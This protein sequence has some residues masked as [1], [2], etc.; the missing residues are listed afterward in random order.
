[1]ISVSKILV[2]PQRYWL[3]NARLFLIFAVLF[4]KQPHDMKKQRKLET[5]ER[6]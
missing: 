4:A 1:M 2:R 3:A 5:K 6:K